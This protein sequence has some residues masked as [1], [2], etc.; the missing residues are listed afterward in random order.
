MPFYPAVQPQSARRRD[1]GRARRREDRRRDRC[2]ASSSSSR[3]RS[4]ALRSTTRCPGELAARLVHLARQRHLVERQGARSSSCATTSARTTTPSP[5][6]S[7]QG[8]DEHGAVP[9]PG[10]ARERWTWWST[11][12]SAWTPRRSTP[13]SCCRRPP[14]TRRTTSTRPTC[15]RSST[16]SRRRCRR[17]GNRRRDWDIFKRS[18]RR[19]ASWRRSPFPSRCATWSPRRSCTTRLTNWR[20]RRSA[21]GREGECE[22]VPGKTMPHLRVVERD[23]A[24]IYNKFIS[25]GPM[26]REDGLSCNGVHVTIKTQY[27][28]MLENPV[29]PMPDPRHMRCVEWGGKRY[30]SLEDV[31]DACNTLLLTAPETNG[32]ACW[33]AFHHEE[34]RVG[35]PLTDLADRVR[36]VHYELRRHHAPA[37]APAHQPVLERH[38]QRRPRLLRLV[39]ERRAANA[40]AHAHRPPERCTSTTPG[41][42]TS[43]S[44]SRPTSRS[45]SRARPATS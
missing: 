27:D 28:Q 8:Q 11:S 42:W 4:C 32:E 36:G 6:E 22:P 9:R 20:S 16:R 1:R 5:T 2:G 19:S 35:L 13:T 26:A 39:H 33:Q 21:T 12:T 25:F 17:S 24:N 40:L 44:T 45:S 3:T 30:P 29:M 37:E 38:G 43:A 15:T 23:Y 18:R 34:E 41:T 14:G 7:R 10:A 31:L